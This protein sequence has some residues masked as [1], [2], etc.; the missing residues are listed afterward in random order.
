MKLN[1]ITDFRVH[2]E[3]CIR[4]RDID[5]IVIKEGSND[6]WRIDSIITVLK[7]VGGSYE[8]ATLDMDVH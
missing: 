7:L 3:S 6:G 2:S 5:Y 4:N 1:L 8:V